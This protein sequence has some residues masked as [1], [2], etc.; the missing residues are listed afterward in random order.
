[1]SFDPSQFAIRLAELRDAEALARVFD[2][3]WHMS[4]RGV[5]PHAAFEELPPECTSEHWRQALFRVPEAHLYLTAVDEDD[6]PV[7]LATAG[8]DRFGGHE[9]AELYALY[10]MPGYQGLGLGRRLLAEAFRLMHEAGFGSGIV[11]TLSGAESRG[12]YERL[13]GA[14]DHERETMEWGQ[15]FSQTGYVWPD[16]GASFANAVAAEAALGTEGG[17]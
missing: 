11:W 6:D 9:W 13:G 15:R 2:T 1:M 10:V 16:L 12:F 17:P 5:L 8:P 4:Y 3:T 7:G 14:A